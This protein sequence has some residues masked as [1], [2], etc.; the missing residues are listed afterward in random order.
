MADVLAPNRM[1]SAALGIQETRL[2]FTLRY[3][4]LW[5]SEV[6]PGGV[7]WPGG[8]VLPC[9]GGRADVGFLPMMQSRRLSPL[10]RA[11][12]AVAWHCRQQCGDMPSVFYSNHG[13]SQYYFEMLQGM[14]EG[15]KVSPSRF[16]LCVHNAIAGLSSFHGASYQPYVSLAGGTEGLFA[17]FL[18]AA[19]M[20]LETPRVLLVCYEQALPE[21]YRTYPASSENTWALAMVLSGTDEPGRRLRLTRRPGQEGAEDSAQS[22][23]QAILEGRRSSVCRQE[24]SIWRWSLDDD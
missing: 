24:R 8:E 2:N 22:L 13:E 14:A 15:E 17:A 4:C 23:I 16:S 18:E 5:Q 20:L 7:C 1:N 9:N 6:L 21:A 10:A 19:G 11:A 12:C 3:W